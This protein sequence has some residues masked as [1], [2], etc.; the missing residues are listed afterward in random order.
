VLAGNQAQIAITATPGRVSISIDP[1]TWAMGTIDESA[2][3]WSNTTAPNWADGLGDSECYYTITVDGNRAVDITITGP[4]F[5]GGV[6]WT[7]TSGSPG[8]NTVRMKAGKSGDA[9]E[10]DMVVLT[11]S[12]QA[13]ISNL[14]ASATKKIEIKLETGTFTDVVE[15]TGNVTL[16]AAKH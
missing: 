10:A 5:S 6:G 16:T 13:F 12:P 11:T 9:L 3:F 4:T 8:S 14:A 15:K 1:A 2:S 7:L